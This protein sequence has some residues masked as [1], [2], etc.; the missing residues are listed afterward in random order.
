[1][2]LIGGFWFIWCRMCGCWLWC[3]CGG[4]RW[5]VWLCRFD[6]SGWKLVEWLLDIF[7]GWVIVFVK[8][9]F[10]LYVFWLLSC[11]FR[12]GFWC[13]CV[14]CLRLNVFILLVGVLIFCCNWW[15]DWLVSWMMCWI[16]L[17]DWLVCVVV[18]V[19]F[20]CLLSWIVWFR[21][22]VVVL[23]LCC[24]IC[25][26]WFGLGWWLLGV[27][28]IFFR[29]LCFVGWFSCFLGCWLVL[30]C[31]CFCYRV[32]LEILDYS[33][34]CGFFLDWWYCVVRYLWCLW[35][36]FFWYWCVVGFVLLCC[37]W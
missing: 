1:M 30:F 21:W 9:V 20:I 36:G 16:R 37:Y 5:Y 14:I 10:V 4:W 7:C 31:L 24:Y 3:W 12:L 26:G 2:S 25:V 17:V 15:L 22:G 34:W 35:C 13:V 28:W 32:G 6:L 29:L 19:W 18:K 8:V 33:F 23:L 11:D 27:W